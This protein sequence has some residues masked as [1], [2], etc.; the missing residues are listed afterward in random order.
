MRNVNL[1]NWQPF[2]DTSVKWGKM[3][4]SQ[5]LAT[6]R[7]LVFGQDSITMKSGFSTHNCEF[8][9]YTS[10]ATAVFSLRSFS[11]FSQT[12]LLFVIPFILD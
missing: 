11:Y 3:N 7:Y 10:S 12:T 6:G 8:W 1:P 5:K 2:V 9:N 4:A